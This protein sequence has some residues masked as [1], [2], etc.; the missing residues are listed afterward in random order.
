MARGRAQ[1]IEGLCDDAVSGYQEL[2]DLGR[3][4][5]DAGMELAAL[6]ARVTIHSTING[7]PDPDMARILSER[8]LNL[9]QQ[10][11]DHPSQAKILWNSMLIEILAGQ[12]YFEALR[13]G[14]Q[15]LL[16]AQQYGLDEQA[17]YA[18]QDMARAH[19]AN[20]QFA[21]ASDLLE[22]AREYW[23]TSGNRPMLA[24][25]LI[26]SAG[27]LFAESTFAGGNEL[28]EEAL[29]VSRSIGSVHLEAAALAMISQAHVEMGD[30]GLALAAVEEGIA[31]SDAATGAMSA[32][33][34]GTASAIYG[35][36][37]MAVPALEEAHKAFDLA[38]PQQLWYFRVSLALALLEGGRLDEAEETL[39]HSYKDPQMVSRRNVEHLG[40]FSA[41]PDLVRGELALARHDYERTLGYELESHHRAAESG[42]CVLLP[43]LLRIRS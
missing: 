18:R 1:E 36:F 2:E 33:L 21:E 22:G 17:A 28:M 40:M 15:S 19:L 5:S 42:K 39:Q 3:T 30:I 8:S 16:I 32:L 29:D 43:D 41:L 6:L 35:L 11:D 37:G 12:D 23:R 24:D 34:H 7:K 4:G 25:N 13:F 26:N 10:L 31:K 20:D 27:V 9:A 14:E 38:T